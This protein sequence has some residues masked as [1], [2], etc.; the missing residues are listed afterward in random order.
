MSGFKNEKQLWGWLKKRLYGKWERV[1]AIV[2]EGICDVLGGFNGKIVFIELKVGAPSK[3]DIRP[4]QR[5]F[6]E[7]AISVGA[8][9]YVVFGSKTGKNMKWF[10]GADMLQVKPPLF[11]VKTR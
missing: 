3:K 10:W 6:I 5:E 11:F 7:W 2:P 1:E 9:V 8:D 4:K